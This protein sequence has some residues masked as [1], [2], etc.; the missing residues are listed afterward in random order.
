MERVC[1]YFRS[2]GFVFYDRLS[3]VNCRCS[4]IKA[5]ASWPCWGISVR[6]SSGFIAAIGTTGKLANRRRLHVSDTCLLRYGAG[7]SDSSENQ[8]LDYRPF[9]LG[10]YWC[11]DSETL[12]RCRGSGFADLVEWVKH[13]PPQIAVVALIHFVF[14]LAAV[15]LAVHVGRWFSSSNKRSPG[16]QLKGPSSD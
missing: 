16:R 13:H 8:A 15:A 4:T 6:T 1:V 10:R 9:T 14:V 12:H 3:S 2:F 7:R 5:K 11:C